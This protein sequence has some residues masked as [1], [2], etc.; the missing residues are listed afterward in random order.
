EGRRARD[1]VERARNQVAALLGRPREQVVFTSGGTEANALGV[2]GLAALVEQG[3]GP[4]VVVTTGI[5]HPSLAGAVATLARRGWEVRTVDA[6]RRLG[7]DHCDPAA[8]VA[9]MGAGLV[10]LGLANHEVGTLADITT[11]A[12]AARATGALVHVDAVQ[13]AAKLALADVPATALAISAHKLGGPQGVGALA[14]TVDEALPLVDGG[15][16]ERGR[17]PGTE[18]FLGVIGFGAA[19][20]A[21]V[22]DD[23]EPLAAVQAH[24]EAGLR[25]LP[26]VRIHGD[27][28]V[29]LP[30]TTNAGFSGALGESI[31]VA[32][33]L[34]GIAVSTGAACTSGSV[35][36]SAVLLGLGYPVAQAREAVRF[37]LG[38]TTTLAEV[39]AV[40]AALPAILGRARRFRR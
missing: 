5:E 8:A 12:A 13:A 40:L 9:V 20:A 17:R 36:P 15:H 24:L 39:D 18:N 14:I 16:Q 3:G 31:V 22:V 26:D 25:A 34:A 11:L 1:L 35:Q 27:A 4:R 10:A 29:R 23:L 28:D 7:T 21:V 37:S 32:L 33:D 6:R 38:R 30:G 19:A 2:L